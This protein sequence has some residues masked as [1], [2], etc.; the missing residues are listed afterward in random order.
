MV[1]RPLAT[2]ALGPAERQVV[3]AHL[4]EERLQ[5]VSPAAVYATW[6]KGN[7]AARSSRPLAQQGCHALVTLLTLALS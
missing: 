2:G 1:G 3:W 4:H 6:T 7:I 5:E